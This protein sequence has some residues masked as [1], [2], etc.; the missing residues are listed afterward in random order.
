MGTMGSAVAQIEGADEYHN[1][2]SS[3][4]QENHELPQGEFVY[5]LTEQ[6]AI[7][8]FSLSGAGSGSVSTFEVDD[9]DVSIT[10]GV[11]VDVNEE[12]SN[13]WDYSYQGYV[14]DRSF[15]AGDVLLGVAYARSDTDGAETQAGFKYRYQN[16]DGETSFS[17]TF[18]QDGASIQ[19]DGDWT[20]Y[21][22]PVEIG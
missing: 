13:N 6:D 16:T 17:S 8:A 5:G 20:R 4:L 1:T 19:P 22:F 14:T 7:D 11:R 9:A 12:P 10:Q 21:Y 18:V 2:L 15:S 3:D